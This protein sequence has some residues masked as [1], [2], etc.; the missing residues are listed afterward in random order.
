LPLGAES[1]CELLDLDLLETLDAAEVGAR[2]GAELPEGLAVV[3]AESLPLGAPS[4]EHGLTG[5]RYRVDLEALQNGDGGAWIDER[6]EAF[7]RAA[8]FPVR[9]RTPRGERE[10]DARAL[11]ERLERSGPRHLEIDVRFTASGSIKPSEL[12]AAVLGID[13]PVARA[14]QFTKTRAHYR[15]DLPRDPTPL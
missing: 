10:V 11:T 6:L 5:F 8:T 1:E 2:L 12:L 3:A 9:K 14:L 4:P 15:P 7:R 13:P